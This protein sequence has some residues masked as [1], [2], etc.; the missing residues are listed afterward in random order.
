MTTILRT[1]GYFVDDYLCTHVHSRPFFT[2]LT[3]W[4]LMERD[5]T[6][7]DYLVF[8]R[9]PTT[10]YATR[11][12]IME[13]G[14][15]QNFWTADSALNALDEL[16]CLKD[17]NINCPWDTSYIV[18]ELLKTRRYPYIEKLEVH[19][20]FEGSCRKM[21]YDPRLEIRMSG[22]LNMA[23]VDY[24][25]DDLMSD[26][27]KVIME[28]DETL[29]LDS[30][31]E[32][33]KRAIA[34]LRMCRTSRWLSVF[35][36]CVDLILD[37]PFARELPLW[38]LAREIY[39]LSFRMSKD[40]FIKHFARYEV[41]VTSAP[42]SLYAVLEHVQDIIQKLATSN[43]FNEF[44]YRCVAKYFDSPGGTMNGDP[45]VIFA[46]LLDGIWSFSAFGEDPV[47]KANMRKYLLT[48]P[49]T[50]E[51]VDHNDASSLMSFILKA[52]LF[53]LNDYIFVV[54]AFAINGLLDKIMASYVENGDSN[55]TFKQLAQIEA[56]ANR[57]G[58]SNCWSI[59]PRVVVR[60]PN[61]SRDIVSE[62]NK[63][64]AHR[65]KKLPVV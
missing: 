15:G 2:A 6:Y 62:I 48:L 9:S 42:K 14:D 32:M 34:T 5:T 58:I 65:R 61:E 27:R 26:L 13:C 24:C 49:K 43:V 33:A 36:E 10:K 22:L 57:D 52:M 8:K 47:V 19:P 41:I 44:A 51:H 18:N 25:T 46:L 1:A 11:I 4:E 7:A 60:F 40:E 12:S 29:S 37:L 63:V 56:N 28:I 59:A 21:L 16:L 20:V 50:M 3:P 31:M 55:E 54:Q 39:K 64:D 23:H 17:V 53:K 35:L 45:H 38:E 30:A